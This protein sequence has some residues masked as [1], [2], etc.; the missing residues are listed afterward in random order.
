VNQIRDML[1]TWNPD[2][3][4]EVIDGCDHFYSGY[5]EELESILDRY[6]RSAKAE[7]T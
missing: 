5:L 7:S 6:L 1:P 4:F 2:A 3:Q